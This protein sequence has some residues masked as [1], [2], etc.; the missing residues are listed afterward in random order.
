MTRTSVSGRP[1]LAESGI[2]GLALKPTEV[3]V[4]SLASGE[5]ERVADDL[6]ETTVVIDFEG[7]A[8]VPDAADL[9]RLAER[10]TALRLTTPVRAD[11]FDPLGDDSA[12]ERLP[13]AVGRVF[14]AGHPAYLT[15]AERRRAIAPRLREAVAAT[16]DAWVGTEGIERVA[17]AVGGTQFEL[18]TPT[19]ERDVR[20]LRA[21]G[22][23]GEIALYAPTVR[24]TDE[25]V[26]LDALGEYVARR[27]G[28]SASLPEGAATDAS[29][30][31][32]ARDVLSQAARE[33]ALVGDRETVR[34][35]TDA[36]RAAGVDRIVAYPAA[37][38]TA[39]LD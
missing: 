25:D 23:D 4:A 32:E 38:L 27:A 5:F 31:G 14:V 16:P 21:A 3:D 9:E 18:L 24:S 29:A 11:G 17:L 1:T 13:D 10:T 34:E 7:A 15:E 2:D 35:R 39:L 30:T 22:F 8:A 28:V 36:L 37:G 20:A 6:A 33:Y 26:V 12:S 19:V